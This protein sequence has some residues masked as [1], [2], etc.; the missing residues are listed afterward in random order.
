MK[1]VLLVVEDDAITAHL[2]KLSLERAGYEVQVS[3]DGKAALDAVAEK[4]PDAVLL[5]VMMP[6]LNGIEVL[7]RIK[8][9]QKLRNIPVLIYTNAFVPK[10][11]D[12][13]KAAGAADVLEKTTLTPITLCKIL[14]TALNQH[15]PDAPAITSERAA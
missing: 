6:H 14:G 7:K 1:K 11:I 4:A 15:P 5:D 2:Y 12:D 13:A 10:L 3:R 9:D 8:G